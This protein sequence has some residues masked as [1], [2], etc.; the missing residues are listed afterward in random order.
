MRFRHPCTVSRVHEAPVP[1]RRAAAA[2]VLLA[3]GC[4]FVAGC[5]TDHDASGGA[6]ATT[7]APS[8][9]AGTASSGD[10]TGLEEMRKKVAA[11][12][13]AAAAADRDTAED[14][15]R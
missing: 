10:P 13:S 14:A 1:Q 6:P 4:T 8:A 5:G 11:A 7:T 9:S 2:A 12:E 15:D 3:L